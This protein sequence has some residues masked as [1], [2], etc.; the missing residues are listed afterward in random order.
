MAADPQSM[1]YMSVEEY[2]AYDRAGDVKHEYI[3]GYVI[4]LAGGTTAHNRLTLN[5]ALHFY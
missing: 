4:A 5:M 2:L 3:D 1:Q